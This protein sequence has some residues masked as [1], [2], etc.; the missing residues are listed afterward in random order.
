MSGEG[1][2]FVLHD[3]I[4]PGTMQ[5]REYQEKIL[6]TA[7]EKNT[8]VV[9]PTG[10]G[11]TNI[12]V[13]LA[14]DRLRDFPDSR[15]LVLAPTRP[16]VN[17]HYKAFM[18]FLALED[19][20]LAFV[21]GTV[22][23]DDRKKIY[24]DRFV[25][26]IFA[27]P[28]TVRNDIKNRLI[29]LE[30]YSLLVIDETHHSVGMYA[31]PFVVKAYKSKAKNQRILG[32]T[33]SPGSDL[34]KIKEVMKNTGLEAVE[35]RTEEESDVTPYVMDRETQWIK[36][37]LPESFIKIKALIDEVLVK[38]V[39]TLRRMGYVY[40][41]RVSKKQLLEIQS[42][43]ASGIKEGYKKAFICMFLV[44]QALKL[45]HALGLLETQGIGVLEIYWKKIR[46]GRTKAD[47]GLRK[48]KSISNAMF[49]TH[50]LQEE[51]AKHPKVAMLLSAVSRQISA[52]PE[53]KIIVFA[54]YRD[55][56]KEITQALHQVSNAR[57]TDFVGQRE[58]MSQKEQAQTITDFSSGKHNILVCTS[59]GEEGLDIPAMDLAIFYEPVPSAIRSIQRRGRVARQTL[60]KVIFLITKG[61][62]DEAYY[63]SSLH[64]EKS[65]KK[66][67]YGMK[68]ANNLNNS[69]SAPPE[70][71]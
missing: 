38:K 27:T 48:D 20:E 62:R 53:S 69:F 14:A 43:A 51:G 5:S 36:V 6:K 2:G 22:K 10:L 42:R 11:K 66:A 33:A 56:V 1:S 28:Q 71:K 12:A 18:S 35:I 55:S 16:L 64:K 44:N 4:K 40:G 68:L 32:L 50:S 47:I 49:L 26:A 7:L 29:S 57:P 60:G 17:Q 65:M 67:L 13:L 39:E 21:T 8:L 52:N 58:G 30:D 63:W 31:Y 9:I 59:I 70:E 25:R 19:V 24:N 3:L 34:A 41:K 23:P 61:T 15:I 46:T 45:E 37:E 54:N